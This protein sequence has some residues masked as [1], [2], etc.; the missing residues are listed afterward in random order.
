MYLGTWSLFK[1]NKWRSENDDDDDDDNDDNDERRN[2]RTH[3]YFS[4]K[5]NLLVW[6]F[7]NRPHASSIV[8]R[9]QSSIEQQRE[10]RKKRVTQLLEKNGA[11]QRFESANTTRSIHSQSTASENDIPQSDPGSDSRCKLQ[12]G[13]YVWAASNVPI[14]IHWND[15]A[16][17]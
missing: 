15:R 13:V 17:R 8:N 7:T 10:R 11:S 5:T 1:A 9:N 14:L 2:I 6:E 12:R 16:G 3:T 4:F